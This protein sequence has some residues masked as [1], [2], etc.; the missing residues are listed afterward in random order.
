MSRST[1]R[2]AR[3][4]AS[5]AAVCLL[6]VDSG[7][8]AAQDR[9][10]IVLNC[11]GGG[12]TIVKDLGGSSLQVQQLWTNNSVN[13]IP[14]FADGGFAFVKLHTDPAHD[15]PADAELQHLRSVPRALERAPDPSIRRGR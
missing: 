1:L 8:A 6:L 5:L 4:R 11:D 10:P 3:A 7:S 15:Q 2:T 13:G 9:S 12:T 14:S